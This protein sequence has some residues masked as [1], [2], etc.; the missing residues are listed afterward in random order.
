MR[1]MA[2]DLGEKRTGIAV[3]DSLGR[4]SHPLDVVPTH[5]VL[6]NAITFRRL[7]EDHEIELL[8]VGIPVSLDGSE[9]SQATRI[10]KQ[11]T[12]LETLYN[13][14]VEFADERF[15]SKEAKRVLRQL[16]YSEKDMRGKTDKI[17]ASIVLQAW[18]DKRLALGEEQQY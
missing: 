2:L 9:H 10:R 3:S 1:I 18:L 16:G 17:A 11:A 6:D 13:L 12:R 4:V 8:L 14:P 15:S 5:D 7:L